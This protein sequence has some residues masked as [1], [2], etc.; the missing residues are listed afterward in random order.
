MCTLTVSCWDTRERCQSPTI[1]VLEPGKSWHFTENLIINDF[2]FSVVFSDWI[3]L[4]INPAEPPHEPM[5]LLFFLLLFLQAYIPLIRSNLAPLFPPSAVCL[6]I[7][8]CLQASH[9]T[10]VNLGNN[11]TGIVL[12]RRKAHSCP[13]FNST[14][15]A[16]LCSIVLSLENML[17]CT[18]SLSPPYPVLFISMSLS[19]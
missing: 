9:V 5:N 13:L 14:S 15:V 17:P 19:S 2:L 8:V 6:C 7:G 12:E 18:F 1:N 16:L 11:S 10:L 4:E 3:L